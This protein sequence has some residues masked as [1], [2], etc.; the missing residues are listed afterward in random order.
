MGFSSIIPRIYNILY[1][2]QDI[3]AGG[4]IERRFQIKITPKRSLRAGSNSALFL[5]RTEKRL[6]AMGIVRINSGF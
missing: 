6:F 3:Y 2:L 4:A 1:G 5:L